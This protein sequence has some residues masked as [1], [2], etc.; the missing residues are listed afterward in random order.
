MKRFLISLFAVAAVI[1][2]FAV[3]F[4]NGKYYFEYREDNRNEA[5]I[6]SADSGYK[7]DLVIP[8]TATDNSG[9]KLPVTGIGTWAFWGSTITTLTLPAGINYIGEEPFSSCP[10]LKEFIVDAGNATFKAVDG[11][12]MT[13]DGTTLVAFPAAKADNYVIPE[14][15]DSI[16][17]NAFNDCGNLKQITIPASVR[18]IGNYAFAA[19]TSLSEIRIAVAEPIA[20]P[21][22][23]FNGVDKPNCRLIVPKGSAEAYSTDI[24][25]SAF[26]IEEE[27]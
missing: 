27:E 26:K 1:E 14:Q 12:L 25:W 17:D 24:V 15:V 3:D 7:G 8:S 21:D 13:A 5:Q 10:T 9:K 20:V 16:G 22:N 23:A 11:V 4:R 18:K 6:V 2:S 19:C